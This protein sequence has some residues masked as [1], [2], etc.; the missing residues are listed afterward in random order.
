MPQRA[1][2]LPPGLPEEM[3][4]IPIREVRIRPKQ[5]QRDDHAVA[6]MASRVQSQ[7]EFRLND[8]APEI[9][10]PW[11]DRC[12]H[13]R[14]CASGRSRCKALPPTYTSPTCRAPG[15]RGI[16]PLPSATS[17]SFTVQCGLMPANGPY[18]I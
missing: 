1:E 11:A 17:G 6:L 8:D 7:V 2:Q 9:G 15:P 5:D 3:H 4:R 13:D 12:R 14:R 10:P 18:L 16:R